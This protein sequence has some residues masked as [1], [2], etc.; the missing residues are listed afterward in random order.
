[1]SEKLPVFRYHPDPLATGAVEPSPVTCV[2]CGKARGFV[3]VAPVY[4]IDD[5]HNA[6]CPWC[7]AEGSAAQK[8]GASFADAHPLIQAGVPRAVVE[9][10]SARTPGYSSWQ[11]E[12]WLA[13]CGDACEFH[14]DATE[15]DVVNASAETKQHWLNEYQQDEKSWLWATDGYQ[16]GGDSAL[17][18]FRCRHCHLT[19]FG[20]DLS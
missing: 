12:S 2:C 15:N 16:A 3:Y 5:L 7:I 9:E 17:Y 6:L 1:M 19:L 11:G 13:H 10:V 8:L 18:K 4:A 20:W 14:G